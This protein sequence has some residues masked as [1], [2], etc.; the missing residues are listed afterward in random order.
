[1]KI[2]FDILF[3]LICEHD[4]FNKGIIPELEIVPTMLTMGILRNYGLLF[5]KTD[6]GFVVLYEKDTSDVTEPPLR[7]VASD[8]R[9]SFEV[10]ISQNCFTNYTYIPLDHKSPDI[11]Y[12]NN[13]SENV[14]GSDLLLNKMAF[15]DNPDIVEMSSDIY[16]IEKTSGNNSALIEIADLTG[17]VVFAET[18]KIKDGLLMYQIDFS[19]IGSGRYD[20][21]ID[22]S[23]FRKL[24]VDREVC[25][26]PVFGILDIFKSD[27]VPDSYK[28]VEAD[29]SVSRKTY[30]IKFSRRTSTW[31]Y[32]IILR[33][34]AADPGLSISYGAKIPGEEPYPDT[35]IFSPGSPDSGIVAEYGSG[36]V[37]LFES[38]TRIPFYDIPKSGIRLIRPD[39]DDADSEPDVVIDNLPNA[40][41]SAIKTDPANT[42]TFSEIFI[43]V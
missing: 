32:Y 21:I 4:Y 38:D 15:A 27:E 26:K 3:E 18:V 1:M 19:K 40:T 34:I 37:L 42:E 16:K 22:G 9:F 30:K 8:E 43:Y 13:T 11:F 31:K 6:K 24:Y 7:P 20:L 17:V 23:L 35:V 14:A 5:K 10:Y 39:N 29:G 28:F 12:F 33:N 25:R 2:K 36:K 41:V